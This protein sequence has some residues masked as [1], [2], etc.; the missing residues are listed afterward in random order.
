MHNGLI[1]VVLT[2]GIAI[3]INIFRNWSLLSGFDTQK[4]S[5]GK[6]YFFRQTRASRYGL[7][8]IVS[9]GGPVK[10]GF[11]FS[12]CRQTGWYRLCKSLGLAQDLRTGDRLLDEH[13]YFIADDEQRLKALLEVTSFTAAVREA[14]EKN[15]AN[16]IECTR[17][18][19]WFN[20]QPI[21]RED[22]VEEMFSGQ[23]LHLTQAVDK[24]GA[25][26]YQQNSAAVPLSRIAYFY[27]LAH[28]A[29]LLLGGALALTV[30]FRSEEILTMKA[31][32]AGSMSVVMLIWLT[33]IFLTFGRTSWFPRVFGSFLV[34][35][36]I[37]LAFVTY[38]AIYMIDIDMDQASPEIKS[39]Q[40]ESKECSLYCITNG[41][42]YHTLS[43]RP[44]RDADT[45]TYQLTDT[46]CSAKLAE[47]TISIYRREDYRC[48][49]SAHF[50]YTLFFPWPLKYTLFFPWPDEMTEGVMGTYKIQVG[51]SVYEQMHVGQS[52]AFPVHKGYLGLPWMRKSEIHAQ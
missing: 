47:K 51:A 46:Q 15:N 4:D 12:I 32:A 21:S 19:L 49:H 23:A 40:L 14:F 2:L 38:S 9:A 10:N 36:M 29:L 37:G 43:G 11:V 44:R 30:W 1:Y 6:G 50:N 28:T 17:D 39:L 42:L 35:G 13:Y 8:V 18:K 41:P 52:F 31:F 5:E 26:D 7:T 16:S 3:A 24:F 45:M 22:V 33:P 27:R 48:Q 34:L 20:T 25:S